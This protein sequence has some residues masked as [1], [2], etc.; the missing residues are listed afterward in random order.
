VGC[1]NCP[2]VREAGMNFTDAIEAGYKNYFNFSGR[3]TRSEYWWFV[4]WTIIV[5]TGMVAI[6]L[7]GALEFKTDKVLGGVALLLAVLAGFVVIANLIPSISLQFRRLHDTGR[8]GWWA[9]G[10][11]LISL[12]SQLAHYANHGSHDLNTLLVQLVFSLGG[13]VYNIVVLVFLVQ[14]SKDTYKPYNSY[15]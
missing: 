11:Y 10:S 9:G 6:G 14:P 15:R 3:A 1:I 8:S 5:I 2:H 4:L 13:L 7:V 12:V